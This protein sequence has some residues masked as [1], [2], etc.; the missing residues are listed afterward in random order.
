[1]GYLLPWWLYR[2]SYGTVNCSLGCHPESNDFQNRCIMTP[3]GVASHYPDT[4]DQPVLQF[5]PS[6]GLSP[7]EI[8]SSLATFS[9]GGPD[10]ELSSKTVEFGAE[11]VLLVTK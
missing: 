2:K 5:P 8:S 6:L 10:V 11:S 3:T 7:S 9:E 1:M 4:L